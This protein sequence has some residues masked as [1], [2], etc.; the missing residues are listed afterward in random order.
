MTET[1]RADLDILFEDNSWVEVSSEIINV[2]KNISDWITSIVDD[3]NFFIKLMNGN[4]HSKAIKFCV[5][6]IQNLSD[7]NKDTFLSIWK[8]NLEKAITKQAAKLYKWYMDNFQLDKAKEIC[9]F[10]INRENDLRIGWNINMLKWKPTV[11][12]LRLKETERK[13]KL[14]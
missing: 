9:E 4:K 13:E 12:Q 11:W 7:V 1:Q 6:V 3:D 5:F 14:V 8:E 10:M 2:E